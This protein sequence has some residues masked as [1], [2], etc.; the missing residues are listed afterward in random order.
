MEG[1]QGAAWL[2]LVEASVRG[3]GGADCLRLHQ[4]QGRTLAGTGQ[5]GE[6]DQMS[7]DIKKGRQMGLSG[8]GASLRPEGQWWSL[9]WGWTEGRSACP[10]RDRRDMFPGDRKQKRISSIYRVRHVRPDLGWRLDSVG[11]LSVCGW[12]AE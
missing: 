6:K 7:Q 10:A 11:H 3:K 8:D 2:A 5:L 1:A 12:G 4:R 9:P